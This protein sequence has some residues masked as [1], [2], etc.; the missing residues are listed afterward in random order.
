M[1][2]KFIPRKLDF[3]SYMS[4]HYYLYSLFF[5]KGGEIIT[6]IYTLHTCETLKHIIDVIYW[7]IMMH[8]AN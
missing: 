1:T 8:H 3:N 4:E 6:G 2:L 5:L 7:T